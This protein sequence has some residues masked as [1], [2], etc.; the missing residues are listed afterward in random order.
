MSSSRL[1]GPAARP[2]RPPGARAPRA[3]RARRC[4]TGSIRSPDSSRACS[5]ESQQTKA[6][7]SSTTLSSSRDVGVV[8]ADRADERARPQPLAA[9]HRVA[10]GR[11]RDDDVLRRPRRGGS[12]PA[13]RRPRLQ[14]ASSRF[15]V[16]AVGDDPLDP[17]QR[18]ADA[19]DLRLGLPAAADHAERRRARPG[20]VLRRDPARRAGAQLAERVGLDHRDELRRVARRRARRRSARPSR[21]RAY[22]FTPA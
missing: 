19:R 6:A 13:R 11:D 5:S 22:V 8:R 18:R 15:S 16:A 14:N 4:S 7:R 17:R 3:S 21:S 9:Q 2:R 20:E 10:R 12:R 1:R